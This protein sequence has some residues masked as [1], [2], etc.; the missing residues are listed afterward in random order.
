MGRVVVIEPS[1]T[2]RLMIQR[3]VSD[4]GHEV[5]VHATAHEAAGEILKVLPD[6]VLSARRLPD[7]DP[8]ELCR[9][10]KS[11]PGAR[12]IRFVVLTAE[13]DPLDANEVIG[14]GADA[15]LT[16]G[17]DMGRAVTDLLAAGRYE[18]AGV[19]R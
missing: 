18:L 12:E 19:N 8:V 5:S 15:Y 17:P 14:A 9:V 10:L 3:V 13:A 4:A 7:L 16:K 11:D 1:A 2:Q 6:L